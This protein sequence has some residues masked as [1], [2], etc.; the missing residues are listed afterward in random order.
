MKHETS[1]QTR[2]NEI[3][4]NVPPVETHGLPCER[5]IK[6]EYCRTVQLSD[7]LYKI[8]WQGFGA[9]GVKLPLPYPDNVTPP[10]ARSPHSITS[11]SQIAPAVWPISVSL[12]PSKASP[13]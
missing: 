9:L 10:P 11:A 4:H 8:F 13:T 3:A 1:Q 7:L 5:K 6:R 12:R 2:C